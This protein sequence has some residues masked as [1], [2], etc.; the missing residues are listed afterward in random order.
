VEWARA[1]GA[2]AQAIADRL[3]NQNYI[4][5]ILLIVVVGGL[6]GGLA[7]GSPA[8]AVAIIAVGLMGLLFGLLSQGRRPQGWKAIYTFILMLCYV[9]VV[10]ALIGYMFY[11][12][13][14]EPDMALQ[15]DATWQDLYQDKFDR[16]NEDLR[17]ALFQAN[18]TDNEGKPL[19][20]SADDVFPAINEFVLT[21]PDRRLAVFQLTEAL[22]R[23][24][25]CRLDECKNSEVATRFDDHIKRFWSNYRCAVAVIA[26]QPGYDN[27][28]A[29][30]VKARYEGLPSVRGTGPIKDSLAPCPE[31]ASSELTLGSGQEDC[32]ADSQTTNGPALGSWLWA[33]TF[34]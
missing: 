21:S 10:L 30:L 34:A 6:V 32:P 3:S 12:F 13:T 29:S 11:I 18:L 20:D 28:M 23:F 19:P 14:R 33:P 17:I 5:A 16:L 9:V 8:L 7:S 1:L 24:E 27:E 15:E 25:R 31:S 4:F 2:I 26:E 22:Q